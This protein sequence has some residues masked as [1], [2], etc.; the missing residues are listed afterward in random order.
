MYALKNTADYTAR[1]ECGGN[2]YDA[3]IPA[4][5]KLTQGT[6]FFGI[7]T[8]RKWGQQIACFYT[9][10]LIVTVYGHATTM[11]STQSKE[12]VTDDAGSD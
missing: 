2:D 9:V 5:S 8:A 6:F 11:N 12:A 10:V 7:E 1:H 4:W 3:S